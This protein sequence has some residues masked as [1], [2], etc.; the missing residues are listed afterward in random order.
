M[1]FFCLSFLRSTLLLPGLALIAC[2]TQSPDLKTLLDQ[3]SEVTSGVLVDGY[4]VEV[5]VQKTGPGS[6]EVQAR[7]GRFIAFSGL[8]SPAA[9][10]NR[11]RRGATQVM[12]QLTGTSRSPEVVSETVSA[13]DSTVTLIYRTET[14]GQPRTSAEEKRS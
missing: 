13:R 11:F 2:G 12:Q 14:S 1:R 3:Q 6:Y 8:R 4:P 7:E 9:L 10:E 5:T